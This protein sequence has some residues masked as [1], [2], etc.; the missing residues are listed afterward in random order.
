MCLCTCYAPFPRSQHWDI[1]QQCFLMFIIFKPSIKCNWCLLNVGSS[2]LPSSR[3]SWNKNLV[4][5]KIKCFWATVELVN[6]LF[7]HRH[8][9]VHWS[10]GSTHWKCNGISLILFGVSFLLLCFL[11]WGGGPS[12]LMK[13]WSTTRAR[14]GAQVLLRPH[15]GQHQRAPVL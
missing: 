8:T 15:V 10:R 9:S 12:V 11:E 14:E 5:M 13:L 7:I 6:R 1:V 2:F 3:A 4:Q